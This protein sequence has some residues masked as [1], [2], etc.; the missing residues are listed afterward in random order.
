M[1][2]LS[3]VDEWQCDNFLAAPGFQVLPGFNDMATTHP[4]LA[5]ELVGTDPT[6]VI[7]GTNKNL[8][9]KCA[10]CGH[11]WTTKGHVRLRSGC[12]AC[13]PT[14]Y[15][16]SIP[17]YMYLMARHGEQRVGI[18]GHLEQRLGTHAR[19]NWQ[20]I[21]K[22]GPINDQT[23]LEIETQVRQWLTRD[24]GVIHGTL[25]NWATTNLEVAYLSELF[26]LPGVDSP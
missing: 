10:K 25:E 1:C 3:L 7:A 12:S 11:T 19:T 2:G 9:W 6:T 24:V 8:D 17:A 20:L 15:D 21:D 18:T 5:R 22:L 23:A 26:A 16:T 14:G 13:S 4:D